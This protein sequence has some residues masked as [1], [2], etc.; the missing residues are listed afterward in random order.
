[1]QAAICLH[2][3]D[4]KSPLL[5]NSLLR[6]AVWT[7]ITFRRHSPHYFRRIKFLKSA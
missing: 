3:R 2:L 1:M 6:L 7:Q 4:G 5:L